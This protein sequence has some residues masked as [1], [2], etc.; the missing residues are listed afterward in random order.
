MEEEQEEGEYGP[1]SPM[2]QLEPGD[3]LEEEEGDESELRDEMIEEE[4]ELDEG[5]GS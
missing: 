2:V 1:N 5:E 3:Q 4:D